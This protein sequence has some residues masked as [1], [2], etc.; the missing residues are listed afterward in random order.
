MAGGLVVE[1]SM[2]GLGSAAAM[3]REGEEKSNLL[4]EE[5]L[6]LR[7]PLTVVLVCFNQGVGTY[8]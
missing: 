3:A 7:A 4:H 8:L 5:F 2:V 6:K 1:E